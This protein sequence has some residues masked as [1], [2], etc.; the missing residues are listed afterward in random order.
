MLWESNPKQCHH[1]HISKALSRSFSSVYIYTVETNNVNECLKCLM[2]N[3]GVI[4]VLIW[5]YCSW[6]A[7]LV[8]NFGHCFK[9]SKTRQKSLKVKVNPLTFSG[10]KVKA[11]PLTLY[12]QKVNLAETNQEIVWY[13][14]TSQGGPVK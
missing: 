5:C 7:V 12:G 6:R 8:L 13:V 14:R 9:N 4:A 1:I 11:N 10:R 3:C 2:S